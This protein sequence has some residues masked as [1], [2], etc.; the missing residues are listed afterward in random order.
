MGISQA[1]QVLAAANVSVGDSV[2]STWDAKFHM[3]SGDR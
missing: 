2:N 3:G 1:A